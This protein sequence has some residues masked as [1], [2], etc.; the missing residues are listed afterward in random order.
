[1]EQIQLF[2]K[3]NYLPADLKS[4]VNDFINFLL[5]KGKREIKKEL[6]NLDLQKDKSICLLILMN[7]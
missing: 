1:M 2:T 7:L 3:L 4:E 6:Q 5:S